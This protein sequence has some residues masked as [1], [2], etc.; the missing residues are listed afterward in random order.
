M[1]IITKTIDMPTRR[2]FI[3]TAAATAAGVTIAAPMIGRN[4]L[5]AN[6]RINAAV[7]GTNG[8]GR[9]LARVFATSPD[10]FVHG[11]GDVDVRAI[12]KGQKKVAEATG[13]KPIGNQDFRRFLDDRDVDAVVIA[14]PDHWHAPMA[15]MAL[16]AGKHVYVEKPCSHNP[17]EGE[18]LLAKQKKTGKL[19][20]MGNQTRSSRTLNKVVD[21]I[22]NGLIGKA[23]GAKAWYAN[24]RGSIG[25]QKRAPKPEWLD[26]ELWQ[27]PA[28][29]KKFHEGLV[30]YDWHWYWDYGTGELL[31]NG[32]HEIDM[33]RWALNVGYPNRVTSSGGRYHFN[34]GWEAFDTQLVGYEYDDAFINWEGRSCNAYGFWGKGRGTLIHGTEGTV[35]MGRWGYT[36]YD[37]KGKEVTTEKEGGQGIGTDTTGG[38]SLTDAHMANF[39]AAINSGA[40]LAAPI[41]EGNVCVTM[42]H[43]GNIAQRVGKS[44]EIDPK[45]GRPL[46]S[47]EAM[48]L[49]EREYEKGWK[50]KV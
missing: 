30:H 33:A 23:Y 43:L 17:Q 6:R 37:K 39:I 7:F 3:R 45:D 2:K 1:L 5:G 13:R 32:T 21:Q 41:D 50:P 47:R 36:H 40:E 18:W 16:E 25:F 46:N 11:I 26:W 9:E 38:G 15:I 20:Q 10:G 29:H 28:P 22:Q 19:V 49:W 24:K 8:R 44:L 27:G 14:T 4:I 35:E 12:E 34:D 42:G 48:A 31:N